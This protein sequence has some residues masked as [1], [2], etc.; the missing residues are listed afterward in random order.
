M[1]WSE[2]LSKNILGKATTL[3]LLSALLASASTHAQLNCAEQLS[4]SSQVKIANDFISANAFTVNRSLAIYSA[5][6]PFKNTTTLM[7][8][9]TQL[10]LGSKWIDMGAGQ[11]NA[12]VDGLKANQGITEGIAISYSRPPSAKDD[13]E[14]P[15]RFQYIDGDFVEN[16]ASAGELDQWMNQVDLITDVF[17][18]LSYSEQLPQLLQIYVDLLKRNGTAV[19]NL[20]AERNYEPLIGNSMNLLDEPMPLNPVMKNGRYLSDGIV[21][22]LRTI[23]G[24]E[25]IEV[26]EFKLPYGQY[27]EKSFAIKIRKTES[28]VAVPNNLRTKTYEA[29][30]PPK[31]TFE[32][33]PA[34]Q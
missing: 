31:R 15:G 4:G 10:P 19:F 5:H 27:W 32:L 9:V 24:I 6:F 34:G 33:T 7:D 20:M 8:V 11:G 12:L 16:L 2:Q 22:W 30:A 28:H 26:A 18:P 29:S 13:H 1:T 25:V 17:G 3:I 14:V 23:A 21:N